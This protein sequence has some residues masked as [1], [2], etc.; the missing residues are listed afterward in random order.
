MTDFQSDDS[1]P[2]SPVELESSGVS[3]AALL[4]LAAAVQGLGNDPEYFLRALTER[5]LAMKPIS[6][7]RPTEQEVR[8]LIESGEFTTEEWAEAVA[9]VTRGELQAEEAEAWLIGFV[10]TWPME[11][12]EQYLGWTSEV[13]VAAVALDHIYAVEI[14]GRLRFPAWQFNV[15]SPS[16]LLPGLA[17][18][19]AAMKPRWSWHMSAAFMATPQQELVAVGRKS[20]CAWLR[21][22]GD[23]R[24]VR[25]IIEASDW[26]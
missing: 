10:A 6:R 12:V 17:E 18:M 11:R 19:I 8:F 22:Q 26:T 1:K 23:V 5:I 25:S 20:P 16:K 14:S 3:E 15:G 7:G 9:S 21:D 4:G 24:V 13:L 2:R